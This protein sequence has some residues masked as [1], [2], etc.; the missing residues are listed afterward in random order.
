MRKEEEEDD[1][2]NKDVGYWCLDLSYSE[3]R[4][5]EKVAT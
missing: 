1:Q 5:R 3:M 2:P 4:K